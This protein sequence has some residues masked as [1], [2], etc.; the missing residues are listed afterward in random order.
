LAEREGD[1]PATNQDSRV[2]P[3]RCFY[4]KNI[5]HATGIRRD[6]LTRRNG[7]TA[8]KLPSLR[9]TLESKTFDRLVIT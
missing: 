9:V 4:L 2:E 3:Y 1:Q 5:N 7:T 6:D 8:A